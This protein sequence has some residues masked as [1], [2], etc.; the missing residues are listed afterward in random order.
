MPEA[1]KPLTRG[2]AR[3]G[4]G[5]KQISIDSAQLEQLCRMGC[6]DEEIAAWF[7]CTTRTIEKKK[8]NPEF[9]EVMER[10]RAKARISVRRAQFKLLENGN[11]TMAIFLGKQLLGQRDAMPVEISG[12]GGKLLEISLETID[13]ILAIKKKQDE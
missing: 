11:C 7:H 6:A 5:R 3:P 2:G 4:S 12:P 1:N 8:K 10:G 13:A 9:A